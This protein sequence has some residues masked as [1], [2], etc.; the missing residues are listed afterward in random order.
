ML[1]NQFTGEFANHVTETAFLE[2]RLVQTR[3]LLGFTLVFCTL[4]YLAFFATDVAAL[5]L[6]PATVVLF[7]ARLVV[8][9]TA[10]GCAW[11]AY[12]RPLSVRATRLAATIAEIA[13]L[14]CFMVVAVLRPTEFH[15]HAMSL[16]IML[17][18]VYLYIP[19]RLAYAL[20]LAAGSTA[21]FLGLA[22]RL[23]HM[24]LADTLTM[25]LLLILANTFGVLAARRFNLV[26]REEFRSQTVLKYA[27]DRDHLTDCFNRRY[28]HDHLMRTELARAQRFARDLTVVLCDIDHFKRI[29]DSHGHADGDTVLRSFAGLLKRMTRDQVDSVV[30]YGGEEFLAILPETDLE[31]GVRLAER[32]RATFAAME[33]P[34]EDGGAMLRATA[35]FGVATVHF[36]QA[37]TIYTLHD[38]ISGADKMMYEA[39]RHGR[40][41][42]ESLQLR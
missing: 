15:W 14:G 2:A 42:V 38:L 19:N 1:I 37:A 8:G 36:G 25:S 28:L 21:A 16:S 40:N 22:W 6:G 5:G 30:R 10:G 11:L 26:S 31:G 13:A 23:A 9:L 39:K 29:N 7:G 20:A 24:T 18:V 12:R 35:S 41:R 17:I 32:V 27:A 3:A 4:F 33:M 34:S